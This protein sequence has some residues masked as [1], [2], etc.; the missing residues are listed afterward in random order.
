MVTF[1]RHLM[2]GCVLL[3]T[4]LVIAGCSGSE[5]TAPAASNDG[6]VRVASTPMGYLTQRIAGDAVEVRTLLPEGTDPFMWQP[7]AETIGEYQRSLLIVLNGAGFEAWAANAA[8]PHSKVVDTSQQASVNLIKTK[9]VVHT[10]GA[11]GAHSHGLVNPHTWMSPEIAGAQAKSIRDALKRTL[12]DHAEEFDSR[13]AELE[14]DLRDLSARWASVDTKGIRLIGSHPSYDYLAREMGWDLTNLILPPDE[15]IDDST[16]S[17]LFELVGRG[18]GPVIV[19]WE[20]APLETTATR[21]LDELGV[22]SVVVDPGES[23]PMKGYLDVM[24]ADVE[25]LEQGVAAARGQ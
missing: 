18:R 11:A 22:R 17:K 23:G 16:W 9:G 1:C 7:D 8:L 3:G 14:S 13:F 10:H 15:P 20:S 19:L 2:L 6:V 21:L 24:R 12:P 5:D 25:A 4:C